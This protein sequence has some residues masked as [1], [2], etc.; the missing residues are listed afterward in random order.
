MTKRNYKERLNKIEEDICKQWTLQKLTL[1]GKILVINMLIIPQI[2]YL[3]PILHMPQKFID[4]F[5]KTVTNC[6]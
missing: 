4:Q 2:L 6:I 3:C 1:K 5:K